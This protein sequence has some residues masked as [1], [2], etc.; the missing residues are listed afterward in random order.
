MTRVRAAAPGS[1]TRFVGYET[2]EVKTSVGALRARATVVL[3]TKFAES[4]FYAGGRRPGRGLRRRRER[5]RRRRGCDDVYRLGDDQAVALAVE[6]GELREGERVRLA[7]DRK[8]RH[9]TECNHTATHLLHAALRERLGTHVRQAGSAV[10][11]DKLRFDFTHGKPLSPEELRDVEDQVNEWIA[12]E[13]SRARAPHDPRRAPRRWAR[14]RC[15]ARSTA[16][17][18]AMIEVEDVSRE[19]CGGT[20]VHEHVRDRRLQD[21]AARDRA[22]RTC[23]AIEAV[24]GP[25]AV[26]LLRERD[27]A[28]GRIAARLRTRPEDASARWR[29]GSSAQAELEREQQSGGAGRARGARR[30]ARR[31]GRRGRR[32]E[33]RDRALRAAGRRTSCWSCPTG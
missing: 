15:S 31:R 13:P 27:D 25:E 12:G 3:L 5:L 6:R 14:W 2:T 16:T 30:D 1:T 24:T 18:C 8:A 19:L 10:R 23:A 7:V 17:R 11:P 21:P 29:R 22:P 33:G 26:R 9:A 20:H 32:R 28:L 4:P